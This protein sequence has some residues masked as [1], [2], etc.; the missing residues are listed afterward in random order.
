[1]IEWAFIGSV[2]IGFF[3]LVYALVI[4]F[5]IAMV[6]LD[7]RHP[8]RTLA[9]VLVLFYLPFVGLMFYFFFG[10][11]T[12]HQRLIS[13]KTFAS[14]Y[15]RPREK[16]LAQEALSPTASASPVMNFFRKV[17]NALPFE[18]ND[19]RAF[20]T[21]YDMLH[22]LLTDI[23]RAHH[24]IHLEFYIFEDDAVGRLVRDALLDKVR[25]GVEV[26]LLYDDVGSWHV[27]N[28]FFDEMKRAGMEVEAFL[29]VRFPQFTGKVNYRNHRKLTIIDGRVGYIGG[30]NIALRYMKGVPWG[31]WRDTH[32]RVEG[33]AVYGLQTAFL[34]DWYVVT[35][36]L[37][38]QTVYF[39]EVQSGGR[40]L[41]QIVTCDP[42]GE[43]HEIMQG[44][45]MAILNARKYFYIETPY[46]LPTDPII[47]ALRTAALSGV[48]VRVMIPERGDARFIHLG[49][50]SYLDELMR[51]GVKIYL[52]RKGFLHSK[53][54]VSDDAFS[55]V[56]ST[57]V[58]FRSF[59]HNFEVNAFMYDTR[60]A[61]AL[62]A[63]FMQDQK[64][65]VLLTEKQWAMRPWYQK[66][67]ESVVRLMAPLL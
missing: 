67:E 35:Q 37:I 10:R 17:S 65:A 19:V 49:T 8:V 33:K 55:T 41:M 56:G 15:K 31:V 7:N 39:P 52:Y 29:K 47:V 25:Q 11:S 34:L 12:R 32:L 9:W 45:L 63:L 20:T 50:L 38:N 59:E 51:A 42:I 40:A 64:E 27:P 4:S 5:T 3:K 1:M 54:M 62:K 28:R 43:W 16:Y 23:S 53:L 58:D 48:D 36:R 61:R 66:V 44:L 57:N 14:L 21:G 18:G 13:Y 2:F 60:S 24:H 26:R 30:M 22:S 6:V 46:L